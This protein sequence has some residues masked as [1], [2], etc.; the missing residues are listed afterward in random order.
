MTDHPLVSVIIPTFNSG[1]CISKT[2]MSIE[3]SGYQNIEIIVI[4]DGSIDRTAD[5]ISALSATNSNIRYYYQPNSGQSS[6]RNLGI[7]Q[8]KGSYI[9]FV[10]S[11]DTLT[12]N[13]IG[14]L[15]NIAQNYN[16][17]LVSF[18]FRT[19]GPQTRSDIIAQP[20]PETG[21]KDTEAFKEHLYDGQTGNFVWSYFFDINLFRVDNIQFPPMI[22]MMEDV[23]VLNAILDNIDEVYMLNKALY[24]Y[25]IDPSSFSRTMDEDKIRQGAEALELLNK[26]KRNDN[27]YYASYIT[28]LYIFLI[29]SVIKS[30]SSYSLGR[31]MTKRLTEIN[32]QNTP[33]KAYN[34]KTHIKILI[35]KALFL[36]L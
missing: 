36:V 2:I 18:D 23:V 17:Q 4:D 10:D 9:M 1:T 34:L 19:D 31:E 12:N 15:V 13:A 26:D 5:I 8:A 7:A 28:N 21:L 27:I 29:S 32:A 24:C 33:Q 22:N 14:T 11:G 25:A 3:N 35:F 6:A 16:C 20:Y 30:K